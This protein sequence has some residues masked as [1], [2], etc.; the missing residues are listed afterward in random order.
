MSSKVLMSSILPSSFKQTM[1]HCLMK[2]QRRLRTKELKTLSNMS[3]V[4]LFDMLSA[5]SH[6]HP[7]LNRYVSSTIQALLILILEPL[8]EP[9]EMVNIGIVLMWNPFELLSV[10]LD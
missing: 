3:R 7:T 5:T 1:R 6:I 9:L 4:V 10:F 8:L 2:S